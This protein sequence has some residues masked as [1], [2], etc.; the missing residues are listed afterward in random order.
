MKRFLCAALFAAFALSSCAP[1]E[2]TPT[3]QAAIENDVR[4]QRQHRGLM[5]GF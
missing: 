5:N 4:M 1:L 2:L 3:E